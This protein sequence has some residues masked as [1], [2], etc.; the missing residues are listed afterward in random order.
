[1]PSRSRHPAKR[2]Y[3]GNLFDST[4]N[5]CSHLWRLPWKEAGVGF[6][7]DVRP[8]KPPPLQPHH[9]KSKTAQI[10]E[11]LVFVIHQVFDQLI[12]IHRGMNQEEPLNEFV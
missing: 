2:K 10:I 7:A 1:M 4:T 6:F 8:Q 11:L 12:V 9:G 5:E 3:K